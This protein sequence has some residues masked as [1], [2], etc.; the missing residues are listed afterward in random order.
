MD[1]RVGF[2]VVEDS[3]PLRNIM[4]PAAAMHHS[5]MLGRAAVELVWQG[6]VL[7]EHDIES[8]D[9]RRRKGSKRRREK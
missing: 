5:G 7:L 2:L 6:E 8:T 1:D 9:N 4:Q 3:Q